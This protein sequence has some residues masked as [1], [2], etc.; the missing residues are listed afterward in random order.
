[1]LR[2][3]IIG[4]G[5]SGLAAGRKLR[6]RG[7]ETLIFEK[8]RGVGGRCATRRVGDFFWDSG[9]TSVLPRGKALE[10][11]MLEELPKEDLVTVDRRI[12]IHENLRIRPGDS[13]RSVGNRY[14]YR[15]GIN[16]LAKLLAEGLQVQ[17]GTE[18][19]SL[20]EV[21]EGVE[22]NHE[23]FDYVIVTSPIPQ[24]SLLLWSAGVRR[25]LA[26]V[27]YRSCISIMLGYEVALPDLP[28]F[29][30]IDPDQ[31]HPLTWVSLESLK[32][33]G[34][35]STV[36]AQMNR[37]FSR[38]AYDRTDD[39]LVAGVLPYME[40]LLGEPFALPITSSV[41]R[42]KYSQPES[43]A[44]FEEVNPIGSRILLASDGLLGGHLEDSFETGERVV[45]LIP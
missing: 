1:M 4:A 28:Y 19:E 2:V 15:N 35:P 12:G 11:V 14:C 8:S 16:T 20:N 33:P 36:V 10:R 9:A 17:F 30:L 32:V 40:A 27:R 26:N 43:T 5:I 21:R 44:L 39:E 31:S 23:R 45:S 34:R 25:P 6:Q 42:W 3:A 29:A 18:I 41:M 7:I 38:R 13:N 37:S 22:I 24:A